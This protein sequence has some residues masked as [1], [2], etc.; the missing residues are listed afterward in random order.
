MQTTT[1]L[2]NSPILNFPYFNFIILF[3]KK[4]GEKGD[5]EYY[6]LY[7]TIYFKYLKT[8]QSYLYP[9]KSGGKKW[10]KGGSGEGSMRT[11][12]INPFFI[13]IRTSMLSAEEGYGLKRFWNHFPCF[14]VALGAGMVST[15]CTRRQKQPYFFKRE[16]IRFT[17]TCRT[18]IALK[19]NSF[20]AVILSK[21]ISLVLPQ[22]HNNKTYILCY[23]AYTIHPFGFI[24]PSCHGSFDTKNMYIHSK[25]PAYLFF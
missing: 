23:K 15:L 24:P 9:L 18:S 4:K 12:T 19:D 11:S 14:T 25:K 20:F 6:R 7:F 1:L 2:P 21:S 16:Y 17:H 10:G 5:Y 8:D 22:A 13:N 3:M